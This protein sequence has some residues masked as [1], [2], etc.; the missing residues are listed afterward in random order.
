MTRSCGQ[1]C[2]YDKGAYFMNYSV[3]WLKVL[4][5]SSDMDILKQCVPVDPANAF[6]HGWHLILGLRPANERRRYF[7]TTS[8][9]GWVQT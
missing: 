2:P 7:V 4:Y 8:L 6:G 3:Y 5:I 1:N 9:I